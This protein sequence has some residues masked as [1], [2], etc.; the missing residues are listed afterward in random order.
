[1]DRSAQLTE[2]YRNLNLFPLYRQAEIEKFR[3]PYGQRTLA[4]LRRDI[5]A[6]G[7]ASKLIF[8]GHRGCG[9]STLLAQLAQQMRK[10]DLFVAG[11]SIADT[12]EMSD[13]NHINILYSIA[14]KLLDQALKF[15][16]PIP[17]SSRKN[18][19]NWFTETK[20]RVYAD[21]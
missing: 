13:V 5:L 6:S 19:I 4:K 7:P 1:M 12:V 8:T 21:Q 11:F 16:V 9:K 17:E 10:A 15:N 14:L 20:T 18:L 3:V 2:A